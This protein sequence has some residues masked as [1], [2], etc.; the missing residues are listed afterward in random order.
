MNKLS[1]VI[2]SGA[3]VLGLLL[4]LAVFA[5]RAAAAVSRSDEFFV[6]SSIDRSKNN[7]VLLQATEISEIMSI[8]PKTQFFDESGKPL[9]LTDLRS[10]DT[11]YIA[12]HRNSDG[13]VVA[14]KVSKGT[15]TVA[16]LRQR[17]VPYLPPN[18]GTFASG[19]A[20]KSQAKAAAAPAA[21][22]KPAKPA[23]QGASGNGQHK[24]NPNSQNPNHQ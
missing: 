22:Q 14:D 8:D 19:Q 13:G 11:V 18:A 3:V 12:S 2:A 17:Y 9:K 4:S 16:D 10:G 20:A 5:P 24:H 1:K 21:A 15:M 23:G 7:L 6:I